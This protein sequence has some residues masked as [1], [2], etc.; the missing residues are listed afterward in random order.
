MSACLRDSQILQ[1]V[2]GV[3]LETELNE[4]ME[5]LKACP[6]CRERVESERAQHST[7]QRPLNEGST[8]S[9]TTGSEH[10]ST[11]ALPDIEGYEVLSRIHAGAQG[12]VYKAVQLS[13]S[14]TVAVKLLPH[15]HSATDRQ[16]H[17]FEREVGLAASLRHPN[18][19]T[20]YDSGLT[21]GRYFFAMEY[22]HG[23]PLD[24]YLKSAELAAND[25]LRL[26]ATIC[27]AVS[28]AHQ[29]GV[30]HRDLKPGN[31]LIDAAVQPHVVDFGLAKSAGVVAMHGDAP[32]TLTSQFMGTLAYASPEQTKGDPT[33]I[34]TRSDVYALGVILYEMLTGTYPYPMNADLSKMFHTICHTPP[35]APSAVTWGISADIDTI[36]LR[37]LAKE[38]ERRYQT[39]ADLQ[40]DI[41]RC[42][43]GEPI[44]AR[45]DSAMYILRLRA[46]ALVRRH[47]VIAGLFVIAL[48]T[49][50]VAVPQPF[51]ERVWNQPIKWYEN[52]AMATFA[53]AIDTPVM[54]DVR[55]VAIDDQTMQMIDEMAAAAGLTD[56]SADNL[57]SLRRLH[58]YVLKKL[59]ADTST[60]VKGV[61]F[62]FQFLPNE[63]DSER[64]FTRDLAEGV[65]ALRSKGVEPVFGVVP[66][67]P[68]EAQMADELRTLDVVTGVA[69]MQQVDSDGPVQEWRGTDLS[70]TCDNQTS[71]GMSV[72]GVIHMRMAQL[73][74]D[75]MTDVIHPVLDAAQRLLKIEYKKSGKGLLSSQGDASEFPVQRFIEDDDCLIAISQPAVPSAQQIA[76][77]T[78]PFHKLF[79]AEGKELQQLVNG[80]MLVIGNR[81]ATA[82]D[83]IVTP[84]GL[85]LFGVDMHAITADALLR[86]GRSYF[87]ISGAWY[88]TS[89]ALAAGLGVLCTL[90]RGRAWRRF[91]ILAV[92]LV[93]IVIACVL[94]F[95]Q[96]G[97]LLNPM[98]PALSMMLAF[99]GGL[100]LFRGESLSPLS[101]TSRRSH[102]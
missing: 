12:V 61:L 54:E 30:I 16:K 97:R 27:S 95:N 66:G 11:G 57:R 81:T 49:T 39:V 58:G 21:S 19:V 67:V 4:V 37:A 72:M 88:W 101:T 13:T 99:L 94:L 47:Q 34:D 64:S 43:T 83:R 3:T 73:G 36:V 74:L 14:R 46:R 62:D 6:K 51:Y 68:L 17:R 59:A 71:L 76:A 45:R 10:S 53:P 78:I 26:F 20:V 87:Y 23:K 92:S 38:P 31:I 35:K 84:E 63:N 60:D 28:Y 90:P 75:P 42:L 69:T 65:I 33:L 7:A 82:Q 32:F 86:G 98:L 96:F 77:A 1:L 89:L 29:K 102:S 100:V 25:K 79:M 40:G 48:A 44:S 8:F 80:K 93:L 15:E 50:I 56:V 22:I 85:D 5:H 55:I 91:A 9:G 52:W 70:L 41:E 18:I 2:F 24:Q